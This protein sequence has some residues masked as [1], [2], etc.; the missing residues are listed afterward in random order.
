MIQN[1]NTNQEEEITELPID[2]VNTQPVASPTF[3]ERILNITNANDTH[4]IPI[5]NENNDN[6]LHENE[7]LTTKEAVK[8]A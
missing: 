6:R 4:G 1:E 5:S 7:I 2:N 8:I 3:S